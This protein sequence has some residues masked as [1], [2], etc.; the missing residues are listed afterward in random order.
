MAK[1]NLRN[2]YPDF[3]SKD[4][5]IDIPDEI[6]VIMHQWQLDDEAYRIRTYRAKAYYSMDRGD[7]I[8]YDA[9]FTTQSPYELYERKLTLQ[10]LNA[11]LAQLPIKQNQ[12]I[13]AHYILGISKTEIAKAEGVRES[14]VR[15]SIAAGLR[16]MKIYLKNS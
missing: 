16:S 9:V 4:Y 2:Y 12:R 3:Y 11:A 5:F 8:E 1:L 10:Q 6:A 15:E 13:Y 14:S 7:G